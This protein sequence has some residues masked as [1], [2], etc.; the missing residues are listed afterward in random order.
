[1]KSIFTLAFLAV[2]SLIFLV[3]SIGSFIV[4]TRRVITDFWTSSSFCWMFLKTK[5]LGS[6]QCSRKIIS[7]TQLLLLLLYFTLY[8]FN[9]VI[10]F[11]QIVNLLLSAFE[12]RLFLAFEQHLDHLIVKRSQEK[13]KGL[14]NN[15][16]NMTKHLLH[17]NAF[18]PPNISF[19]FAF[20]RDILHGF[21][22]SDL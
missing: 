20:S 15:T 18:F 8:S 22:S 13:S 3:K 21:T 14:V 4:H 5:Y 6:V 2:K 19:I 1:M 9:V 16:G 7:Y 11:L 12:M 17:K 10:L